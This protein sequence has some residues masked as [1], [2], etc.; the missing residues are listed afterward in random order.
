[1]NTLEIA[2][3]SD[4][5]AFDDPQGKEDPSYLSVSLPDTEPGKHPIAGLLRLIE[6]QPLKADLVVCPGDLGDK[7]R[8]VAIKYAWASLQRIRQALNAEH[9][10]VATGNHDCDSRHA[11]NSYDAKGVLQALDPPYPLHSETDND[12]YWA[13]NFA[14]IE[15]T[16]YRLVVLNS[17]AYHGN[18]DSEYQHGR[19]SDATVERLRASLAVLS[20]KPVNILLCHHHPQPHSELGLGEADIMMNGQQLLD[21]LGSGDFGQWIVIHGH[22]HHPK[23]SYAGGGGSTPIVFAAGSLSAIL[24]PPLSSTVKNQFYMMHIPLDY[25]D[26]FGLVGTIRSWEWAPGRGWLPSASQSQ[27][28]PLCGFG[29]RANP[30]LLA[31]QIAKFVDDRMRWSDLC[32]KMP[33]IRF[34]IPQDMEVLRKQLRDSYQLGIVEDRDGIT[35]EIGRFS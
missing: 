8:P 17:S 7:A 24:K 5:H 3:L 35:R 16:A 1:M 19:V 2:V 21:L 22:K 30:I 10:A 13:R 12:K 6:T 26:E 15:N 9:L 11:Y 23:L 32:E 34:L 4:L 28:P 14:Y 25:L 29:T 31:R 27:L 20:P 18:A 33:V